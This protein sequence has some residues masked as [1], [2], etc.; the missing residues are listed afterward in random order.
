MYNWDE[1]YSSDDLAKG[2]VNTEEGWNRTYDGSLAQ[3]KGAS[4]SIDNVKGTIELLAENKIDIKT[5]GYLYL[6]AD[7]AV[8]IVSNKEVNIGGTFINIGSAEVIDSNNNHRESL[9][10]NN[11]SLEGGIRLVS[12]KII[13]HNL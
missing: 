7:R 5:G 10:E 11:N 13:K 8:D 12:S 6:A 3:I 4:M 9:D 1:L 2:A